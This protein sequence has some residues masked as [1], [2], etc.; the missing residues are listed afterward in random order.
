MGKTLDL[1]TKRGD[2]FLKYRGCAPQDSSLDYRDVGYANGGRSLAKEVSEGGRT[3]P[4]MRS[5]AKRGDFTSKEL[6][7]D[8]GIYHIHKTHTGEYISV[9]DEVENSIVSFKASL[10]SE[11]PRFGRAANN[12]SME[13]PIAYTFLAAERQCQYVD[14]PIMNRLVDGAYNTDT[15][16]KKGM[17][18]AIE[19]GEGRRYATVFSN[20]Q[21]SSPVLNDR[22]HLGPGSFR[23][24][25]V[26]D[27]LAATTSVVKFDRAASMGLSLF[28]NKPLDKV[29]NVE[30][31]YEKDRLRSVCPKWSQVIGCGYDMVARG[32]GRVRT[33][34]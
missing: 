8:S 9:E 33:D 3:F 22:P 17:S 4:S 2:S 28:D 34:K 29:Y 10:G 15:G 16:S 14:T 30:S 24:E 21:R 27:R 19:S 26:K 6:T 5:K 20:A 11:E 7:P 32:G 25:E 18:K 12:K 13:N 31:F 1:M 23:P